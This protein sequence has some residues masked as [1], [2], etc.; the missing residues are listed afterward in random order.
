M[1]NYVELTEL[2]SKGS[3][4]DPDIENVRT[5]YGLR[6]VY[7]NLDH[8]VYMDENVYLKEATARHPIVPGLSPDLASFSNVYLMSPSSSYK[9]LDI[10]GKPSIVLQKIAEAKNAR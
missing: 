9:K 3:E 7:I 6:K 4:Y 2:Y 5:E 1:N 10:I 8:I